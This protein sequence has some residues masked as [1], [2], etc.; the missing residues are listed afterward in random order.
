MSFNFPSGLEGLNSL[1]ASEIEK[2]LRQCCG[3]Q[4]WAQQVAAARPFESLVH[5]TELADRIWGSLD[6]HDWLEAFH[7][8]PKIGEKKAAAATSAEAQKWS[9]AEQ[10]G[11]R[12]SALDTME[13]LARLN[14][15]YHQKFGFIFII[16]AAGKTAEEML[17]DLRQRLN[18][19]PDDELRIAASEQAKITRLRL[20]KLIE[21]Q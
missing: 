10:A 15:D 18:N 17:V 5:L 20:A 19:G 9:E 13:A 7:S 11:A 21:T 12:N 8:H 2:E 6:P 14:R 4:N 16:C 1:P 3:S